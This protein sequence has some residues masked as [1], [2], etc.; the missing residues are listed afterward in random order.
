MYTTILLAAALQDWERYSTHALAARSVAATLAKGASKPLHVLS[1]YE[2]PDLNTFGLT[3]ELATRHR[4]DLMRRTD[5]LMV[6]KLDEYL[7]PLTAEGLEV[8]KILRLGNPRDVLVEVATAM[9]ADL[10]IIGSH[11]KRGLLDIALG[12]TAQQVSRQAPCTV[13]LVS[14]KT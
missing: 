2:Y 8:A 6:Q 5:D 4:E 13:L 11:S 1:V 14:P 10:L 12:G 3:P 7:A 9:Q